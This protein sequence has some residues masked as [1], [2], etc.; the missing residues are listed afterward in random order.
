MHPV[1]HPLARRAL[2]TTGTLAGLGLAG[3]G[4]AAGYEV[5]AYRLRRYEVPVL[6]AGATP[7]RLLHI[8]DLHLLPNHHKAIRWRVR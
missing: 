1:R 7:L 2:I 3:L 8:S 5:R 6:P 4:Y